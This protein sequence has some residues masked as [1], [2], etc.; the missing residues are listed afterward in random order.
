VS[1]LRD[2]GGTILLWMLCLVMMTL[3]LGGIALDLWRAFSERRAV[4]GIVDA[5]AI[6]GASGIDADV[7]RATN[8]VVLDPALAR[9]LAVEHLAAQGEALTDP[10]VAVSPDNLTIAVTGSRDVPF[11]L[12]KILL[13]DLADAHVE[14]TAVSAPM[15]DPP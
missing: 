10:T 11:T 1:R 3:F 15:V 13:P 14:A 8:R 7:Y 4:A 5:A 12:L 2:E 9:R 6:A